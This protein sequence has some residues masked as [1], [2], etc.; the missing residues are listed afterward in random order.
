MPY[1]TAFVNPPWIDLKVKM[2]LTKM[3]DGS[4][5]IPKLT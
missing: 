1:Q 2:T 4:S 3:G 5:F